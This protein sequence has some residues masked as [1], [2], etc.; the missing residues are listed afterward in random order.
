MSTAEYKLQ[1]LKNAKEFKFC[2][3]IQILGKI[4]TF[5]TRLVGLSLIAA[6]MAFILMVCIEQETKTQVMYSVSE[7]RCTQIIRNGQYLPCSY[8]LPGETYTTIYIK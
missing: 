8:L 2:R 6:V 1:R 5:V 3:K 7:Q 4:C